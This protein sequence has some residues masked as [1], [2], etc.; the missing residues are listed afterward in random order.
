MKIFKS[1]GVARFGS[2]AFVTAL[3]LLLGITGTSTF[4]QTA[5]GTITG[6]VT[7]PK[8]LAMAG[9][10]VTVRNVATGVDMR[11]VTTNDSGIYTEKALG[12]EHPA[13]A[14]V[15]NNLADSLPR[16]EKVC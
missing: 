10:N 3:L 8:G 15:L 4:G 1:A 14:A 2:F 13:I 12:T 16:P 11:P 6:T 7:D 5:T 9:V